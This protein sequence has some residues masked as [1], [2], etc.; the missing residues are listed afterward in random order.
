MQVYNV[1]LDTRRRSVQLLVLYYFTM[2]GGMEVLAAR[3]QEGFGLL[4]A[5]HDLPPTTPAAAASGPEASAAGTSSSGAAGDVAMQEAATGA[6]GAAAAAPQPSG[7]S[8]APATATPPKDPRQELIAACE[9]CVLGF[10]TTYE[11]LSTSALLLD[12]PQSSTFL[13]APIPAVAGSA[14]IPPPKDKSE[15]V[16]NLKA[17]VMATVM[18]AWTSR[19]LPSIKATLVDSLLAVMNKCLQAT[20]SAAS[21]R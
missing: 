16:K 17:K 7:S 12:N 18:P 2:L 5:A 13:T 10:L 15:F 11:Q 1:L 6:P 9:K 19:R 20:P 3:F 14:P 8:S 4:L 21:G